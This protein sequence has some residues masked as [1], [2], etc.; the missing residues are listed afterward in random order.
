MLWDLDAGK[1]YKNQERKDYY[2]KNGLNDD[3]ESLYKIGDVIE[4]WTGHDNDIRAI[5]RIKAVKGNDLYVYNDCYW[6]PIQDDSSRQIVK[7]K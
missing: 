6:F 7:V 5:A 1:D 2:A 4:F 3:S